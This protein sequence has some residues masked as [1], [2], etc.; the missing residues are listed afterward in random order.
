LHKPIEIMQL[1]NTVLVGI[2]LVLL[3]YA[4]ATGKLAMT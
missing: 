4:M 2:G 3:A 1:I